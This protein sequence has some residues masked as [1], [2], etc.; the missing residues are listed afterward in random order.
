MYVNQFDTYLEN[1]CVIHT[2]PTIRRARCGRRSWWRSPNPEVRK[3]RIMSVSHHVL[4]LH[5]PES[6]RFVPSIFPLRQ[7]VGTSPNA[8]GNLEDGRIGQ[9]D[10]GINKRQYKRI[11]GDTWA[12]RGRTT[13]WLAK[14]VAR[15]RK[16]TGEMSHPPSARAIGKPEKCACPMGVFVIGANHGLY[17]K[18]HGTCRFVGRPGQLFVRNRKWQFIAVFVLF[19]ILCSDHPTNSFK[20]VRHVAKARRRGVWRFGGGVPWSSFLKKIEIDTFMFWIFL[21]SS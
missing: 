14:V 5:R 18:K 21:K 9:H 15:A 8:G 3:R 1:M 13:T 2:Y 17:L 6:V 20:V 11:Y 12:A 7:Q 16:R 4:R 10:S 19:G